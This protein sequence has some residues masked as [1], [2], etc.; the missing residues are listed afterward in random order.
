MGRPSSRWPLLLEAQREVPNP[1]LLCRVVGLRARQLKRTGS[2]ILTA[3]AIDLALLEAAE[4]K[5]FPPEEGANPA[6]APSEPAPSTLS[7][8]EPRVGVEAAP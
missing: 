3:E 8:H 5:L 7:R 1:F 2:R 6:G 4:G